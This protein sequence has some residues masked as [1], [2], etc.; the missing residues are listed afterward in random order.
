[1]IEWLSYDENSFKKAELE[2][3]PV[4]LHITARWCNYCKKM[5]EH[6]LHSPEIV[7]LINQNFIPVH[8]DRDERPDIDSIYQKASYII[9]QGSGWPLT[10]FLTPEG[11]PFSGLNYRVDKGENYFKT[12]IEKA[13]ELY[14]T[15]KDKVLQ[16]SQTIIDAIKPV[17]VVPSEIREDLL[18][19]PEEDIVKEIDFE[20]G[21][22][23]KIPKFPIYSHIDLLLWRYWIKPKPWV[24]NAIEKTLKGMVHSAIYDCVEGGFHRYA[25]DKA[26]LMP[27]FEKL[28]IDNAWHLMNYLDAYNILKEPFYLDIAYEIIEFM[29]NNFLSQ[30]GYFYSSQFADSFYYTW[31]EEEL[32]EI[33]DMTIALVSTDAM[34]DGRFIVVGRDR[35]LVK[36]LKD[37][38]IFKRKQKQTP[39]IDKSVYCSVN[40]LC[41]DTFIKAWRVIK[42]KNLLNYALSAIDKTLTVLFINKMLYRKRGVVALLE[43]YSYMISALISAYEVTTN[44]DYLD[45]AITLTELSIDKLWDEKYGGFFDSPEFILSIRQKNIHD[46]PY[47][48][49]NSIMIINLLK[50]YAITKDE[51]FENMAT[52][53][54]KAMSNLASAY[55]S[56]YYVKALLSYFDMLTLNFYTSVN[57]DVGKATLYQVS[58]FTVIVHKEEDRGYIIPS[59]GPKYFEPISTPEELAKFLRL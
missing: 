42:D 15:N 21:G 36:Q 26:W 49:P 9:G 50:L 57:S 27:H 37:K 13:L 33:S 17:E 59:L 34:V 30:E 16:R 4:F 54:L 29:K 43:D 1:M 55:L 10:L 41:A 51:K 24:L 18:Q 7:E 46:T 6:C 12:M 44:R 38:L 32:K 23:K 47:P 20:F 2:D 56:P 14:K 11:K 35:E 48:S 3:K 53:A 31:S 58:P 28:A 40:G 5:E 25:V 52:F 45:K 39:D 22:L 8:L 19:N